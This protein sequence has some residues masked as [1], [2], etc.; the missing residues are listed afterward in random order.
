L[1]DTDG[2]V[3][4]TDFGLSKEGVYDN[5]SAK[6]F[7][8]SLAYLAPEVLSRKGHG[9]SVD[10]YQFGVLMYELL[11][12]LPPFYTT[13]SKEALFSNILEGK[14]N[15]PKNISKNSKNL[16]KGLLNRNPQ[17]RLGS[18]ALDANEIKCHPFFAD[19]DFRKIL[20]KKFEPPKFPFNYK[21]TNRKHADH[22]IRHFK[23]NKN[24]IEDMN[25]NLKSKENLI[26]GWT[27]FESNSG[28]IN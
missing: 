12:G 14:L 10:W 27:F 22:I 25:K 28:D 21:N 19:M 1:L 11:V 15:F 13:I 7:C 26:Q 9:K 6:S 5:F 4:L 2:Y 16:I 20:S 24:V 17:K 23:N 8:G 18:G 3:K